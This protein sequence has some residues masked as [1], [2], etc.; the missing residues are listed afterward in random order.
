M[1]WLCEKEVIPDLLDF[2]EA[3][4]EKKSD[5][6]RWLGAKLEPANDRSAR[7]RMAL[8]LRAQGRS[9]NLIS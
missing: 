1:N 2:S 6:C 5:A 3:V 7:A 8:S 9:R 4:I